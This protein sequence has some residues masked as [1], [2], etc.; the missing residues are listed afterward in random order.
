MTSHIDYSNVL[1]K[2]LP[3][4]LLH[5]LQLVQNTAARIITRTSY[6]ITPALKDLHWLLIQGRLDFK[7][8]MYVFKVL[9]N[10]A[11]EYMKDMLQVYKPT[12]SLWPQNDLT[13]VV[14]RVKTQTYGN[15]YF[16]YA[17]SKLW[18]DMPMYIRQSKTLSDFKGSLKI[19][20]F[21]SYYGINLST[22]LN[23]Q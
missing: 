9:H 15:R 20:L 7:V 21:K 4:K 12:R 1:L 18:N 16:S 14:P 13:L 10:Q 17:T 5:R 11:P 8:L 19:Y 2:G 6:H 23:Y 22:R 3:K